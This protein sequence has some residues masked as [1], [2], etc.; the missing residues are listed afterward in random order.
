MFASL[1]SILTAASVFMTAMPWITALPDSASWAASSAGSG[2]VVGVPVGAQFIPSAVANTDFTDPT[3]PISPISGILTAHT[4][5]CDR[6]NHIIATTP[7]AGC[8]QI[9]SRDQC[10][11]T[12]FSYIGN[13]IR[14]E[15]DSGLCHPGCGCQYGRTDEGR[16]IFDENTGKFLCA[17]R[18]I[19]STYCS[20]IRQRDTCLQA[21]ISIGG[22]EVLC[23]WD[24]DQCHPGCGCGY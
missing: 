2:S 14:C 15:W 19:M 12:T 5:H 8:H 17:K 22:N 18:R 20:D 11:Q 6:P 13:D 9:T 4:F 21:K 23:E 3:S 24:S 7:T 10:L 16:G 1:P